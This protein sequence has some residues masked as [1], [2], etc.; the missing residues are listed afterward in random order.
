MEPMDTPKRLVSRSQA[1]FGE[2]NV[3]GLIR[4]G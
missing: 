3:L 2:F 1:S 4:V